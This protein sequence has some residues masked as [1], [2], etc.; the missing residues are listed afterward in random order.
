MGIRN[1]DD[2]AVMQILEKVKSAGTEKRALLTEEE[3]K[4][5]IDPYFE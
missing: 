5:I 4:A 1:Y 2:A 3:F